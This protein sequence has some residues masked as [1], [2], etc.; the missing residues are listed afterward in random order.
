MRN[1]PKLNF[2]V[3]FKWGQNAPRWSSVFVSSD[4]RIEN[5]K[6]I[7]KFLNNFHNKEISLA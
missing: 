2:P 1:N 5:I 4:D 3:N 7:D 6:K